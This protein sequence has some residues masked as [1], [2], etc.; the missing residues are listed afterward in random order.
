MNNNNDDD[1]LNITENIDVFVGGDGIT[2]SC[3]PSMLYHIPTELFNYNMMIGALENEQDLQYLINNIDNTVTFDDYTDV[4]VNADKSW[5]GSPSSLYKIP[6]DIFEFLQQKG[7]TEKTIGLLENETDLEILIS[8]SRYEMKNGQSIDSPAIIYS[9]P[10]N[11]EIKNCQHW[12]TL[13]TQKDG[14]CSCLDTR[15]MRKEA[16]YP[17]YVDGLG[18]QNTASRNEFYCPICK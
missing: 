16:T 12:C 6:L 5:S 18:Y 8:K 15:P 2:W 14:C 9:K 3:S 11:K 10:K 7:N 17:N 13:S 1:D 4:Y